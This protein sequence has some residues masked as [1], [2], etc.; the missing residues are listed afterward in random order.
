M[1]AHNDESNQSASNRTGDETKG[2]LEDSKDLAVYK[3]DQLM[4][5]LLGFRF[6]DYLSVSPNE[7]EQASDLALVKIYKYDRLVWSHK[8]AMCILQGMSIS[9]VLGYNWILINGSKTEPY[10]PQ[11]GFRE[12]VLAEVLDNPKGY[13]NQDIFRATRQQFIAW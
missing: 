4:A 11:P 2:L 3:N 6:V 8:A 9:E 12:V 5:S 7:H 13:L 1:Q 10:D